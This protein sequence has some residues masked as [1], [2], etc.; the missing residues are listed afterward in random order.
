[1]FD[2]DKYIN[3]PSRINTGRCCSLIPNRSATYGISYESLEI[4]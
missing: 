1:M 4:N 3:S 2:S